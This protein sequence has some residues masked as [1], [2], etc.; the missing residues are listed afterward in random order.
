MPSKKL[1]VVAPLLLAL[2]FASVALADN[3]QTLPE[4]SGTGAYY[5]PG[6]YQPSTIVGTFDIL[7][8]DTSA[9]IS[10]TFGNS[11]DAGS[12][13]VNLYLGNSANFADDILVGVCVENGTCWGSQTPTPWSDTL[14]APQLASL[15]VGS[16]DLWAVQTSEFTIQLGVT[17][18]DQ[19]VRTPE[20]ATLGLLGMGLLGLGTLAFRRKLI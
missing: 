6:P 14:T 3:I 1:R 16:V 11:T 20:P 2:A 10:G 12:S 18:L 8:G 15:G 17:T 7:A 5:D 13:G 9:T 19:V 4:Y